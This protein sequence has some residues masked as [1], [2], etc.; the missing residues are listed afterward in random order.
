MVFYGVDTVANIVSTYS[1]CC[2]YVNLRPYQTLA[3]RPVAWVANEFQQYVFNVTDILST[4]AGS[5]DKNLTVALESQYLY[6]LNASGPSVDTQTWGD[7]RIDY[8]PH[9]FE[10]L[11]H[12]IVCIPMGKDLGAEGSVRLWLGLVRLPCLLGV[13][14]ADRHHQGTSFCSD[15]Y[16]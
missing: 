7:V 12:T 5:S 16:P 14:P 6:G 15:W 4:S 11:I 13:L 1:G 10:M 8:F 2:Q 3:E 9:S